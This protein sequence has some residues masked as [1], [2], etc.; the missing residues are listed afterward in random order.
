MEYIVYRKNDELYHHGIK[1]QRWGIRRFQNE[2]GSLTSEGKTRYGSAADYATPTPKEQ[3]AYYK[4][5]SKAF[6]TEGSIKTKRE[7]IAKETS[8]EILNDLK[9]LGKK[10]NEARQ[11]YTKNYESEMEKC[12]KDEK[13]LKAFSNAVGYADTDKISSL[14]LKMRFLIGYAYGMDVLGRIGHTTDSLTADRK[15]YKE[16]DAKL[17][18]EVHDYTKKLLGKYGETTLTTISKESNGQYYRWSGLARQ[19]VHGALRQSAE[20]EDAKT[21][22]SSYR[23]AKNFGIDKVMLASYINNDRRIYNQAMELARSN[24]RIFSSEFNRRN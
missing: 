7:A 16:S 22:D 14:E 12:L 9:P 4:N 6:Q 3:K 19:I 20:A 1:G 24:D 11:K 23:L 18:G 13:K 5:V 21:L 8:E 17:F 10:Y 2:D 15:A